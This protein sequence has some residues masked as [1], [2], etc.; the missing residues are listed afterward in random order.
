[1]GEA[2]RRRAR[3]TAVSFYNPVMGALTARRGTEVV[4]AEERLFEL[5]KAEELC[6]DPELSQSLISAALTVSGDGLSGLLQRIFI[7]VG[8]VQGYDFQ[9]LFNHLHSSVQLR[10]TLGERSWTEQQLDER[11]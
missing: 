2:I 9:L 1:M 7:H 4:Q 6:E 10:H 11:D 8:A 5:A 3:K